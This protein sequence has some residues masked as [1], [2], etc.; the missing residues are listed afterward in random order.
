MRIKRPM[1]IS[2]VLSLLCVVA[3]FYCKTAI[4]AAIIFLSLGLAANLFY[5]KNAKAT[6]ILLCTAM[7]IM[8]VAVSLF[9]IQTAENLSS[10]T[11]SGDFVINDTPYHNGSC[12]VAEA[13]CIS[14]KDLSKG[15]KIRL[16]YDNAT[17]NVGDKTGVSVKIYP[18]EYES[19]KKSL[20]SNNIYLTGYVSEFCGVK[21]KDSFICFLPVLRKNIKDVL[22]VAP[23]SY[24]AKAVASAILVGDKG[25]LGSD[26][27]DLI[28]RAGVSHVFVVSGMHLVILM[29]GL[30]KAV[31][32]IF[33]NKYF[34]TLISLFGVFMIS[35]ICSFTMSILRAAVMYMILSAAPLFSRDNDALNSVGTAVCLISFFSPFAIF[36]VAFQLSVL[37]TLGILTLTDFISEK[38]INALKLKNKKPNSLITAV[39]VS[40]SATVM[41][42]PV[43]VYYFEYLSTVAIITNILITYIISYMLLYNAIGILVGLIF[44]SGFISSAFLYIA[45]VLSKY[46]INVI[47]DF[48]SLNFNTIPIPK[49]SAI[50]FFIIAVILVIISRLDKLRNY[51]IS[52][53][54]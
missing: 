10:K 41:T 28:K 46:S 7:T 26:F 50:V 37:S 21:T 15:D 30:L 43:C 1:L 38:I 52:R 8:S 32:R 18:I 22:N 12:F 42:A 11:I 45:G 2:A 13:I 20:Y 47:K 24:E 31:E 19:L 27:E 3:V 25:Q 35:L 40:L 53:R 51:I 23:T 48:G 4:F 16:Y 34:F 6:I 17:L 54:I 9:K 44:G 5:F 49:E 29:G 39:A 33:Y 36:S 14:S